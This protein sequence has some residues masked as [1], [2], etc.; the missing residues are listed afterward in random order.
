MAGRAVRTAL[1]A[2]AIVA[3]SAGGGA[4]E[5][6]GVSDNAGL[7]AQR[8]AVSGKPVTPGFAI[9]FVGV[10]WKGEARSGSVRFRHRAR[11]SAWLPLR[12][13]GMEVEGEFASGLVAAGSADAY[14]VRVP[15][16]ARAARAVAINASRGGSSARSTAA[17]DGIVTRAE[18]GADES[19]R[20][21]Q[22]GNEIWPPA[23]YPAQV[24]T[25]HH[26]ATR[27]NDS[28]PAATVR[29]IYRYHAV[30]RGWG[31]IGYHY[32]I[33]ESGRVYEGRWSGTDGD[34]AHDASGNMVTAAHV[35]G[36]NS[37]N[38]G[39][40]L[41]GTLT[42]RPPTTAARAALEEVLADLAGRHGL[43]PLS[44]AHYVNPITGDT[45]DVDT[46]S[47]H[48]DWE[49]TECP[50]GALYEQLPSLRADVA[51]MLSPPSG[52]LHIG[53]LDGLATSVNRMWS[54]TVT[55]L[56]LDAAGSPFAGATVAGTWSSGA[57][58]SCT[59]G[60]GGSCAL[61]PG[62]IKTRTTSVTFTVTSISAPNRAYDSGSNTDPD[63]DSTGTSIVVSAP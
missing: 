47:G 38:L 44:R 8:V 27:N 53:D 1:L 59:T 21:D 22:Q 30:D 60:A 28:D 54:A 15:R 36:F 14:Q 31:D 42:T 7:L 49:A 24:M 46:I 40:A 48:R 37:G 39:I 9:D 56:V 16:A 10:L 52:A 62:R 63:G 26:T 32:L 58:S 35:G 5:T 57:T 61:T 17:A 34:P 55:A 19:L 45:R 33:D 51:A 23:Y 43:D 13:D 11:W 2:L 6:G 3:V 29:A 50:G 4:A 20:F 12:P 18:W 41:L 25:V